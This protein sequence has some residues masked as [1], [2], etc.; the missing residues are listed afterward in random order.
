M[1][2]RGTGDSRENPTA[3]GDYAYKENL[4][5]DAWF[6]VRI[7]LDYT[8]SEHAVEIEKADGTVISRATGEIPSTIAN[9]LGGIRIDAG[10]QK[11]FYVGGIRYYE[12]EC[13]P[14]VEE[15]EDGVA[16]EVTITKENYH[17]SKATTRADRKCWFMVADGSSFVSTNPSSWSLS[18]NDMPIGICSGI[19]TA[20][21]D[22]SFTD[23]HPPRGNETLQVYAETYDAETKQKVQ[24]GDAIR[25]DGASK[26]WSGDA[27]IPS[28]ALTAPAGAWFTL[29]ITY[30]HESGICRYDMIKDDGTVVLL[31]RSAVSE[32]DRARLAVYGVSGMTLQYNR[33]ANAPSNT[34]WY[35]DNVKLSNIV[36]E[37]VALTED[38]TN[39]NVDIIYIAKGNVKI[40]TMLVA[41]YDADQNLVELTVSYPEFS[42]DTNALNQTIPKAEKAVTAKL[43][44]WEDMGSLTPMI[45]AK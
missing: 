38:S 17:Y 36:L 35:I 33:K 44:L 42:A 14:V 21:V 40:S 28:D 25:I 10:E 8:N 9:G 45:P 12:D 31:G 22:I 30:N 6:T 24:F 2:L 27:T 20:S 34:T 41:Q 5:K 13:M 29:R 3:A 26:L 1:R 15:F 32:D 4:P 11:T 39:W 7:V 18:T 19:T 37:N 43:M 23:T 16:D